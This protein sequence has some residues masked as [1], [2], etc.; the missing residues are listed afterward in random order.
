M[1]LRTLDPCFHKL[2][3]LS[4]ASAAELFFY[5]VCF[6]NFSINTSFKLW[7]WSTT[8]KPTF[9]RISHSANKFFVMTKFSHYDSTLCGLYSYPSSHYVK[10][11]PTLDTK[12]IYCVIILNEKIKLKTFFSILTFSVSVSLF[13]FCSLNCFAFEKEQ[14]LR[15]HRIHGREWSFHH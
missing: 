11:K 8:H 13:P 14:S 12:N 15:S 3:L 9:N 7:K 2:K 6:N 4:R 5:C 10:H 1:N